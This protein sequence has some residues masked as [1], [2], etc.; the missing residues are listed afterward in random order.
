VGKWHAADA[1][2][3]ERPVIVQLCRQVF[4][5]GLMG[6]EEKSPSKGLGLFFLWSPGLAPLGCLDI[7]TPDEDGSGGW[8]PGGKFAA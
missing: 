4:L 6:W 2:S 7:L 5:I 8:F 3:L 1:R